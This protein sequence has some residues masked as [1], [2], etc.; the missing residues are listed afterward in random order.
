MID[1]RRTLVFTVG[2]GSYRLGNEWRLPHATEHALAFAAW[3]RAQGVPRDRIH[4]FLSMEDRK[5]LTAAIHRADVSARGADHATITRFVAHHL[6]EAGGDLLYMFWSGHGSVSED[7]SRVLF[8]EDLTLKNTQHFDV[9]DFLAGLRTT[10]FARFATQIAFIDACANRFEELGFDLSLGRTIAGKGRFSHA[11][12]RQAFFLAADSGEQ[13]QEGAFGAA[14]LTALREAT[15]RGEKWP[16]DQDRIVDVV[17]PKFMEGTQRP[18][19]L[20][21]TTT[22]GDVHSAERVAGEL[23]ASRSVNAAALS[24]QLP[25]RA[26]R[27]LA[28]IALQYG[29]LGDDGAEGARRRDA[30][31]AALRPKAGGGGAALSRSEPRIEMLYIIG[32][33]LQW[34]REHDLAREL[35][36]FAPAA[37]FDIEIKRLALI[38]EAR[39]LIETLPAT[40]AELRDEY[41]KTVGRLSDESNRESASTIDAMLDELYQISGALEPQLPVWEFLLRLADRYPARSE[42]IEQFLAAKNVSSVTLRTLRDELMRERLFVLSIDLTPAQSDEPAIESVGARLVVAGRSRIVR[43]FAPQ[44]VDSWEAAEAR[45]AEIVRQARRIVLQQYRREE[46]ALLVEFLMPAVFLTRAPDRVMVKLAAANTPLGSLHAVVVRL[47][48]RIAERADAINLEEWETIARRIDRDRNSTVHWMEPTR[49][50]PT[51]ETCQGL[52][53]L[54]FLPAGELL[55]IVNEGFPFMA[56]LRSEPDAGDWEAFIRSFEQW[57]GA[58]PLRSLARSVRTIRRKPKD[59]G[60]NLTLLWDDPDEAGHWLQLGDVSTGGD[61]E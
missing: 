5:Q 49:H 16:P 32:A 53:A 43:R 22:A 57:A 37:E 42:A 17:R 26:L 48:E 12:V 28:E 59:V 58:Q 51:I 40:T 29:K 36:E 18:V 2:I 54:K 23:P 24:R 10:S 4:L 9:N 45:A 3:A 1:P 41:V 60:V 50:A 61:D 55:D 34:N 33:A 30:L 44:P 13:A 47:R 20:V 25:V 38:Q 19:Q 21:W 39:A 52:V 8:F 7:G 31:Y 27:R 46:N 35:G 11:D 6:A 14:V 15:A 56:W